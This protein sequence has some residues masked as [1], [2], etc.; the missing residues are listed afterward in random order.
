MKQMQDLW[1][2]PLNQEAIEILQALQGIEDPET[3]PEMEI[4]LPILGLLEWAQPVETGHE[5]GQILMTLL[6]LHLDGKSSRVM[7]LLEGP[8]QEGSVMSG[9]EH[10]LGSVPEKR[11]EAIKQELR[12]SLK[13]M[14]DEVAGRL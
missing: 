7:E 13:R 5:R 11:E 9:D 1:E 12:S 4:S 14:L 3:Q 2:H 10:L 6:E 8:T